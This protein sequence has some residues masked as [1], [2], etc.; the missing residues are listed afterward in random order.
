VPGAAPFAI[1]G[2]EVDLTFPV[3]LLSSGTVQPS[4]TTVQPSFS[5]I[6][7]K[8]LNLSIL[9]C[10]A[11]PVVAAMRSPRPFDFFHGW[12]SILRLQLPNSHGIISFADPHPLNSVKSYRSENHRGPGAL[13]NIPTCKWAVCIPDGVAGPR[14]LPTGTS[15]SPL[16][17]TLTRTLIS[18]DSKPLTWQLNPLDATL[19][20]KTGAP[21]SATRP[22]GQEL[23]LSSPLCSSFLFNHL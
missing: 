4:S 12:N 13:P 2:A 23:S 14:K 9:T 11:S 22:S 8:T 15:L 17:A 1:K 20:K 3:R 18:V 6:H 5:A 16:P 19:T 7:C 21:P 10:Y